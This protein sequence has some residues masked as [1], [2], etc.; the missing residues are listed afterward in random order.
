MT[1]FKKWFI[2]SVSLNVAIILFIVGKRIY[3]GTG[4]S[5]QTIANY[6]DIYDSVRVGVFDLLMIDT[7][8]IVFVG[9]SLTESFPVTEMIGERAVNRGI[10]GDLTCHI[11]K[12]IEYIALNQPKRILLECGINDL[13]QEINEDSILVN[14]G[15]IIHR[16]QE[17]SPRTYIYV[18]SITPTC[19]GY[20]RLMP[21][22]QRLNPK[23][24]AM[25]DEAGV[26]YIDLYAALIK[27][28]GLDSAY[29]YDGVHLN[30]RGY[31][32]WF[33]ALGKFLGYI[34]N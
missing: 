12:R 8:D 15:K 21:A 26:A 9:N 20:S 29:T 1:G 2:V 27:G 31:L 14:I 19:Q 32:Q 33:S 17:L 11:L 25:C 4:P 13:D 6:T 18:H 23:I 24:R 3:Y 16:I 30:R 34:P 10:R 7:N 5:K 28:S 22:I